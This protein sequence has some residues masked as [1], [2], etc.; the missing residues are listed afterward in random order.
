VPALRP[1]LEGVE[2]C[3]SIAWDAHKTLPVP[4][5]AGMFFTRSREALRALFT[6]EARYLPRP[7]ALPRPEPW[8][9]G[10]RWSRG[11]VG[12]PTFA[13]LATLGMAGLGER[14]AH[15][16]ALGERLRGALRARGWA[17]LNDTPLPVVCAWHPALRGRSARKLQRLIPPALW[18]LPVTCR[19]RP[20]L[21]ACV[22]SGRTTEADVDALVDALDALRA[23]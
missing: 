4:L 10:L 1:W 8:A 15:T 14:F 5:G 22:T 9:E 21:R 23:R 6:H 2:R 3:D 13:A 19:G 11:P 18:V 20:A 16:V 12:A 7:G 17:L